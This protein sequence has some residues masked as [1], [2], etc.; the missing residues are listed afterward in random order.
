MSDPHECVLYKPLEGN[1]VQCLCCSHY[2]RIAEGA[3]GICGVRYNNGGKLFLSVY[4]KPATIH[5]D[6]IEKKPLYH[7]HPG[8]PVLSLSTIGCN[9]SCSF[10]QNWSISMD[11]PAPGDIEEYTA[12][13]SVG[14][15]MA[16]QDIVSVCKAKGARLIAFTYNEP[17]IWFEYAYDIAKLAKEDGI[18]SVYVS[19]GFESREQLEYIKNVISAANIDLKSF[20]DETYRKVMKGRVE[21]VKATIRYLYEHGVIVEVTTLLVPGSND[22]SEE[23]R[24]IAEFI[25]GISRDIPWHI[26]A[27]HPDYKMMDVGRTPPE[28]IDRACKIGIEAGLKYIYAGNVINNSF[29]D[30][31]CP[32]CG[33]RLVTRRTGFDGK[34]LAIANNSCAKCGAR[35]YGEF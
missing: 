35:I 33:A 30:T 2:C 9:F 17:S 20:R 1:K 3:N 34:T 15:Y 25:A 32:E 6:P 10:C 12:E 28:A 22:S 13:R 7:F 21:P 4:G 14:R 29:L 19:N 11:K 8:E 31:N 16:P 5:V 23:I 24:D 18:Q 27:F 26:S